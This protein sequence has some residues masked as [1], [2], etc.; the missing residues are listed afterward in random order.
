MRKEKREIALFTIRLRALPNLSYLCPNGPAERQVHKDGGP[1]FSGGVR[2][3]REHQ[4]TSTSNVSVFKA[5]CPLAAHCGG[6]QIGVLPH[7]LQDAFKK[8]AFIVRYGDRPRLKA[9]CLLPLS[10]SLLTFCVTH[11]RKLLFKCM[12]HVTPSARPVKVLSMPRAQI[13]ICARA[14]Y[15][16]G[17]ISL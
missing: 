8:K 12:L 3:C 14:I 5:A 17:H 9:Q 7:L 6:Y 2:S 16:L 13:P 11:V 1:R 4:D 10:V 15:P